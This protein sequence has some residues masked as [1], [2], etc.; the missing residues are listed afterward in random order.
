M[1]PWEIRKGDLKR[2][3]GILNKDAVETPREW[4]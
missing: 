2:L 4:N 1:P 3:F